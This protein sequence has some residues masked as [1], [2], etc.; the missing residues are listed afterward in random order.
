MK[1]KRAFVGPNGVRAGWTLLI[2]LA[3][4][5]VCKLAIQHALAWAAPSLSA[6]KGAMP[7]GQF[8][9][10]GLLIIEAA[11]LVSLA[12]ALTLMARLEQRSFAQYGLTRT[13]AFG[14]LFWKG[15]CWGFVMV[16]AMV[17][18]Q[19]AEHVFYFGRVVL[20]GS[21]LVKSAVLWALAT[22]LVGIYEEVF[23]RGYVQFTLASAMGFW[24]A[25]VL[26][27]LAFGA[28]HL[29]DSFYTWVGVL[30]AAAY[31]FLF[32]LIL[33]R[34]GTLWMAIGFHAA[35]D[36]AE[37]FL[38]SANLGSVNVQGHLLD[39]VVQGPWWLTGGTVGPETSLNGL[40]MFIVIF[41]AFLV[42]F[43]KEYEATSAA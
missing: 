35:V 23:F 22:L 14:K 5:L 18:L 41:A 17:L 19:R 4:Y 6:L 39:S 31:G 36:F 42:R 1:T 16:L 32:C 43:P 11:N 25:A 10:Q 28:T 38:F 21:E 12:L 29:T 37:T 13:G 30:S 34:T 2:F 7:K 26:S 20:Y 8:S 3:A 15:I 40:L 24:P 33:K 9:P 27:S